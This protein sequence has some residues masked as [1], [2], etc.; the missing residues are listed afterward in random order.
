MGVRDHG[1]SRNDNAALA[2]ELRKRVIPLRAHAGVEEGY[3]PSL[4]DPP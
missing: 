2:G 1:V 3:E 4:S